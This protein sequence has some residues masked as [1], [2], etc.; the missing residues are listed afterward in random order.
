MQT[1]F[2]ESA[3]RSTLPRLEGPLPL[4]EEEEQYEIP[5]WHSLSEHV[6]FAHYYLHVLL[7]VGPVSAGANEIWDDLDCLMEPP[8]RGAYLEPIDDRH[9]RKFHSEITQD[10][11]DQKENVQVHMDQGSECDADSSEE[12]E[13]EEESSTEKGSNAEHPR[14]KQR[15][16][17]FPTVASSDKASLK[18]EFLASLVTFP[19]D[20]RSTPAS[21]KHFLETDS[22]VDHSAALYPNKVMC[23]G[24]KEYKTLDVRHQYYLNNWFAHRPCCPKL[25]NKWLAS[26]G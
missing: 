7:S 2:R 12:E 8:A 14:R 18:A 17:L 23:Y 9:K 22:A 16:P 10:L 20:L 5:R 19:A 1:T 21:R 26:R 3:I 11:S 24:C 25:F 4:E 6:D 13:Q 15:N